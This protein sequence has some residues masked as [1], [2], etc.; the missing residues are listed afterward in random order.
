MP[1]K[2]SPLTLSTVTGLTERSPS[3][4]A[5]GEEEPSLRDENLGC[6]VTIGS[7]WTRDSESLLGFHGKSQRKKAPLSQ[8][9]KHLCNLTEKR[10]FIYRLHAPGAY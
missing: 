10:L 9:G 6:R 7:V 1:D 5:P 8:N 4:A 2:S 3:E